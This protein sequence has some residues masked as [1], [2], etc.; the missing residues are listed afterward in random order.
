[1][2][3]KVDSHLTGLL[4]KYPFQIGTTFGSGPPPG[5]RGV[6]SGAAGPWTRRGR[7]MDAP[8]TPDLISRPTGSFTQGITK[9]NAMPSVCFWTTSFSYGMPRASTDGRHGKADF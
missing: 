8:W 9:S 7:A 1:M 5:T 4:R 6:G 3:S 2:V